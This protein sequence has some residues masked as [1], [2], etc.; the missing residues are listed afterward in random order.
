MHADRGREA[1]DSRDRERLPETAR[2]RRA[3]HRDQHRDAARREPAAEAGAVVRDE[4]NEVRMNRR[5]V[6]LVDAHEREVLRHEHLRHADGHDRQ[7]ARDDAD[8]RK[9]EAEARE[10]HS[11]AGREQRAP[12][13]RLAHDAPRAHEPP[14]ER[15]QQRERRDAVPRVEIAVAEVREETEE[16]RGPA[17][18]DRPPRPR[19]AA[20]HRKLEQPEP[21][22]A[23]RDQHAAERHAVVHHE[24]HDPAALHRTEL[25]RRHA[26]VRRIVRQEMPGRRLEQRERAAADEHEGREPQQRAAV[27]EESAEERVFVMLCHPER[28]EGSPES[29]DASLRSA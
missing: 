11:L 6:R 12:A 16:A 7:T 13:A 1:G 5:D 20:P 27:G 19:L 22:H 18:C 9:E 24:M 3:P 8:R 21:D 26:E 15:R 2:Q 23:E 10:V 4:R 25:L 17:H 14:D 29:G 28:S